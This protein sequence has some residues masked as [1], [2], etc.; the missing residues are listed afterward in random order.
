[1]TRYMHCNR[2]L[3]PRSTSAL[4]L[5]P[6]ILRLLLLILFAA[7]L[8]LRL[9]SLFP[10]ELVQRASGIVCGIRFGVIVVLA[11]LANRV[12]VRAHPVVV[13]DVVLVAARDMVADVRQHVQ[14]VGVLLASS[15]LVLGCMGAVRMMGDG[16]LS[17]SALAVHL[18]LF[19]SA[20]LTFV[21]IAKVWLLGLG[22]LSA[23]LTQTAHTLHFLSHLPAFPPVS[24]PVP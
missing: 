24:A 3:V 17:F 1:M 5:H 11:V 2:A 8:M 15:V 6:A 16:G 14:M 9:L 18:S 13:D 7:V 21:F 4:S 10:E 12:T 20:L 19:R 23:H 22:E